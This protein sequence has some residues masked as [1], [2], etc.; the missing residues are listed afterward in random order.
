VR[1]SQKNE[2]KRQQSFVDTAPTPDKNSGL[3]WAVETAAITAQAKSFG[4]ESGV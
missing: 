2:K 3:S 1:S 4:T